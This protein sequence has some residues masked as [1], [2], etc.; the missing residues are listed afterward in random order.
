MYEIYEIVYN[1]YRGTLEEGRAGKQYLYACGDILD[2][3]N[4]HIKKRKNR[5]NCQSNTLLK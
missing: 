4:M 3:Q 5:N 2:T 1:S